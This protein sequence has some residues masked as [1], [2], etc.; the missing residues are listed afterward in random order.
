MTYSMAQVIAKPRIAWPQIRLR[1]GIGPLVPYSVVESLK[2]KAPE[3]AS[4]KVKN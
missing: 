1:N 3:R 2:I 4:V